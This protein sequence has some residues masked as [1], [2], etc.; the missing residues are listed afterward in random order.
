MNCL[1]DLI[2]GQE[3][4]SPYCDVSL[5]IIMR[6][7]DLLMFI[8]ECPVRDYTDSDSITEMLLEF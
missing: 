8:T 6:I 5:R 1:I 7:A 3:T 4:L 2:T